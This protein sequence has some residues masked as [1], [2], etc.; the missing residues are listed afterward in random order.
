[1]TVT[2][3]GVLPLTNRRPKGRSGWG[4]ISLS[5]RSN[6]QKVI[7]PITG[8]R[9]RVAQ[10]LLGSRNCLIGVVRPRGLPNEVMNQLFSRTTFGRRAHPRIRLRHN[11]E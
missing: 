11:I 3:P 10:C 5:G 6:V 7:K 2:L 8:E 9:E 1:M 4:G